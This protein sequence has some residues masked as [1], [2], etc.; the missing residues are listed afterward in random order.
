MIGLDACMPI[1]AGLT[2]SFV[3]G[4]L[5]MAAVAMLTCRQQASRHLRV[6]SNNKQQ[7]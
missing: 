7:R 3:S 6:L 2:L 1:V 4:A 5:A